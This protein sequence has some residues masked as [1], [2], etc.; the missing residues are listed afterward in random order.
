[1]KW[2]WTGLIALVG[3]YIGM[4]LASTIKPTRAEQREWC[5]KHL[6]VWDYRRCGPR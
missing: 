1:M 6:V 4:S 2:L 5:K 3:L